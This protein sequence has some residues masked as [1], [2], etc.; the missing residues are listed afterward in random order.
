MTFLGGESLALESVLERFL[1]PTT[2]LVVPYLSPQYLLLGN[3]LLVAL[4]IV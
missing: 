3:Q 1:G 4:T 2:E